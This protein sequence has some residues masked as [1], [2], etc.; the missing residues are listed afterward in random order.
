MVRFVI[1][2]D[3]IVGGATMVGKVTVFDTKPIGC[4]GDDEKKGG[5]CGCM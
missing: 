4:A 1:K 5:G 2:A 3:E